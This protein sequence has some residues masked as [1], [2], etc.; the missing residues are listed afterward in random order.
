MCVYISPRKRTK[1]VHKENKN[2]PRS[3]FDRAA[4]DALD[5]EPASPKPKAQP[6]FFNYIGRHVEKEEDL[7]VLK[8]L[9]PGKP[10]YFSSSVTSD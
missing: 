7:T 8:Q 3:G 2:L 6:H 10:R 1:T 5:V 4:N 9:V